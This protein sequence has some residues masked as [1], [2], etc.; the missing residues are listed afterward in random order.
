MQPK[1]AAGIANSADRDQTAPVW[2]GTARFVQTYLSENLGL[3]R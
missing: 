3:L 1:D 2:S